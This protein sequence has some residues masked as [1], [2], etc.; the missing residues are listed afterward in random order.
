MKD[1]ILMFALAFVLWAWINLRISR[2]REQILIHKETKEILLKKL[3]S[4][5]KM[6]LKAN[7][8][9]VKQI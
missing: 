7:K 5:N 3:T 4:K 6:S 8:K 9:K 1:H 2:S